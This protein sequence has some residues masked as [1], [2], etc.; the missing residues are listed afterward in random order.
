MGMMEEEKR[1][2]TPENAVRI[3]MNST[4]TLL[5]VKV[6]MRKAVEM[7]WGKLRTI[8]FD[9]RFSIRPDTFSLMLKILYILRFTIYGNVSALRYI[10]FT[11]SY[12]RSNKMM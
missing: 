12:R 3:W 11:Y 1:K 10:M 7:I 9:Q 6:K 8:Q 4:K 5:A 2:K